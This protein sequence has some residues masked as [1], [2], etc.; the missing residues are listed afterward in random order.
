[1]GKPIRLHPKT[2][3]CVSFEEAQLLVEAD[4]TKDLPSEYHL[5]GEEEGE[6]DV[7]VQYLYPWLP[8]RCSC[9][10]KWAQTSCVCC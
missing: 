4:L 6:L 7:V 2:E 5:L 9:C 3:A 8:P 10:Q 1:M